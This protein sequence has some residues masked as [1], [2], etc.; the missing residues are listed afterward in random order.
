MDE[1]M[2]FCRETTFNKKEYSRSMP[3]AYRSLEGQL[4][5]LHVMGNNILRPPWKEHRSFARL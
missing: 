5:D 2:D 3:L 1:R 4:L